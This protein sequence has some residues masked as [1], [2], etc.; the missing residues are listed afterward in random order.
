MM[1]LMDSAR[2]ANPSD[3]D[4]NLKAQ[5]IGLSAQLFEIYP[6]IAASCD[7]MEQFLFWFRTIPQFAEIFNITAS[8]FLQIKDDHGA[9]FQRFRDVVA[10][11]G[12][13][14]PSDKKAS[15]ALRQERIK[16][17]NQDPLAR[18]LH[19]LFL[20]DSKD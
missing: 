15:D 19:D 9:D 2:G 14:F 7:N 13:M 17:F 11:I 4:G 5:A 12:A 18:Y 6:N 20:D 3:K 1:N 10:I 16:S 8:L